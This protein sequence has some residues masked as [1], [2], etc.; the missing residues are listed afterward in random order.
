MNW[1]VYV[2]GGEA[3]GVGVIQALLKV[4]AGQLFKMKDLNRG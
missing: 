2:T 3:E 4:Y 1:K